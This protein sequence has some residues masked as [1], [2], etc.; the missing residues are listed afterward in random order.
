VRS[1]SSRGNPLP[2]FPAWSSDG[3]TIYYKGSDEE[4]TASFWAVP[5]WGGTPRLLV[6]FDDPTMRSNRI[7][8]ATDGN[9]LFFTTT[10]QESDIWLMDLTPP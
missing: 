10:R 2:V 5:V 6:R 8:F 3:L 7:E 9:R 1:D 4:G